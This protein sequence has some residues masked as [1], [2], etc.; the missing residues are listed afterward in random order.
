M[1][2][3]LLWKSC[4]QVEAVF[5]FAFKK[6]FLVQKKKECSS[7]ENFMHFLQQILGLNQ[8]ICLSILQVHLWNQ[9]CKIFTN[10]EIT[11]LY[12]EMATRN[13]TASTS[14]NWWIHFLQLFRGPAT[15]MKMCVMPLNAL[16]SSFERVK[17]TIP[18]VC[19]RA[20][21]ISCQKENVNC[22]FFEV[23]PRLLVHTA[24]Q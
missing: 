20:S 11:W 15:S 14:S 19:F 6:I 9:W 1:I 2:I 8:L 24:Q 13:M 21:K 18:E 7:S 12:S 22:A 4:L 23:L 5:D 10:N 3:S 16:V 17:S